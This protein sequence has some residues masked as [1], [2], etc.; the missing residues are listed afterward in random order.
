MDFISKD[1]QNDS[2]LSARMSANLRS[3]SV[4][5]GTLALSAAHQRELAL[6]AAL[7]LAA[8]TKALVLMTSYTA[9]QKH[10]STLLHMYVVNE[11]LTADRSCTVQQNIF[12]KTLIEVDSSH[13]YASFGTFC[14]QIDH[15]FESLKNVWKR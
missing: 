11:F 4:I 13:L 10:E 15:I 5:M 1:L 8:L 2:I 9:P 14:V 7:N 12:E 3:C 6:W